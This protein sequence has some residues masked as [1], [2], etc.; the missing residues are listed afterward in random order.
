MVAATAQERTPPEM[1]ETSSGLQGG[2]CLSCRA[3]S[4]PCALICSECLSEDIVSAELSSD[5]VLYAYSVVHQ[6]P[7]GWP[8]PYALGYVDLREGVRVLAHLEGPAGELRS[9]ASVRFVSGHGRTA[10][11]GAPLVTFAISQEEQL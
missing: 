3:F 4:F 7:A 5:G 8:V 10:P 2:Q 11:D 9:G 6:A 1:E